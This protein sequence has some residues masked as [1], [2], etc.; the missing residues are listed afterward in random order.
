MTEEKPYVKL[1][2]EAFPGISST[3]ARCHS[4]GFSWQALGFS[5]EG[6]HVFVKESN[7]NI[8]SHVAVLDCQVLIDNKW[9][10]MAALHAVCTKKSHRGQG[11]ASELVLESLQWAKKHSDFQ[12]LFT[13]IPSFYEKLG[14]AAVQ[15]HRF[16]LKQTFPKGSKLLAAI[17]SP[18]DDSLFL[19][20]FKNREPLSHHFWVK[21]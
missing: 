6:G 14:F 8:V 17:A 1:L 2:E 5:G 12:I 11:L 20:C 16:A 7:G 4:L 10:K 13:E 9:H 15:E 18:K 3:I 21:N 19:R